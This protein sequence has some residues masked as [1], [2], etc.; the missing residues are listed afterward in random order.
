MQFVELSK[1]VPLSMPIGVVITLKAKGLLDVM[2]LPT[3]PEQLTKLMTDQELLAR[4][5]W[6]MTDQTKW[7]FEQFAEL[8]TGD[9]LDSLWTAFVAEL[10]ESFHGQMRDLIIALIDEVSSQHEQMIER[11]LNLV[12]SQT[13]SGNQSG[14]LPESSESTLDLSH[15]ANSTTWSSGINVASGVVLVP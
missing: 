2:S 13:E 15:I 8:I 5:L 10:I 11:M 14:N 9:R 12:L 1:T 7:A 4:V 3:N 6:E